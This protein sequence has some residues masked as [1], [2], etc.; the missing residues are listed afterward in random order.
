MLKVSGQWVSP[1]EVEAALIVIPAV[2]EAAV[3]GRGGSG[4][5][6]QAGGLRR[7]PGGQ[8]AQR[9]P[10]GGAEAARQDTLTPHKYP[11]WI[12]FV[13]ELPKTAT[14]KMQRYLLREQL[15]ESGAGES[16]A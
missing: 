8:H 4:Q 3:V 12:A 7:A 13:D 9:G 10:R 5:A 16:S 2:L 11:R 1:V 6:R 15:A 14:G